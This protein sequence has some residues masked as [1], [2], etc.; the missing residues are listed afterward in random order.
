MGRAAGRHLYA[1]AHNR[2]PRRVRARQRRSSI[3][4]QHALGRRSRAPAAVD[5]TLGALVDRVCGR[6]RGAGRVCR[7]VVLRLRF[8]DYEKA[9]RSRTLPVPTGDPRA[10]ADAAAGLLDDAMPL[11][12]RR[13]CTLVGLTV[14]N[15]QESAQLALFG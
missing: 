4:A 3:G 5:A 2:D 8:A 11:I 6:L 10:I 14:T 1:L 13:G 7:T 9:T 12:A 15:L